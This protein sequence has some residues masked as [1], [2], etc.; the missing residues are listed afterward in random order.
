MIPLQAPPPANPIYLQ[1]EQIADSIFNPLDAKTMGGFISVD[2]DPLRHPTKLHI[3]KTIFT[4]KKITSSAYYSAIK[5]NSERLNLSTKIKY[6]NPV[7]SI[8]EY[9]IVH[10]NNLDVIGSLQNKTTA[11]SKPSWSFL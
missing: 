8:Q 7:D 11:I 9:K 5:L 10:A 3:Q 2:P 4:P 6:K 1:V